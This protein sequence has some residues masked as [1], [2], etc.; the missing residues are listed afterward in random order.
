MSHNDLQYV[1][2][3]LYDAG[4][5]DVHAGDLPWSSGMTPA[6]LQALTMLYMTSR[7]R[8]GETFFSLTRTGYGAIGKEPPSLFPFLRRLF[9]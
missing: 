9:G 3:T 8:G 2:Q 5:R 6:I 1:L 4:E 7:E